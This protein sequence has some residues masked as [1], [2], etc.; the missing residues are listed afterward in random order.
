MSLIKRIKDKFTKPRDT[1]KDWQWAD[2]HKATNPTDSYNHADTHSTYNAV[3]SVNG[4][5]RS[6]FYPDMGA[7]LKDDSHDGNACGTNNGDS[8]SCGDTGSPDSSSDINSSS[9][10][11]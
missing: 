6:P 5:D 11:N 3:V 10:S 4:G 9:G 1:R 2:I 8:G 7:E